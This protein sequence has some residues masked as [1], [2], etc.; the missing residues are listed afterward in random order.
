MKPNRYPYSGNKK[1]PEKQIAKCKVDSNGVEL[2]A[3]KIDF[4]GDIVP[5][6]DVVVGNLAT[7]LQ[8]V[9]TN[10]DV[11]DKRMKHAE[12]LLES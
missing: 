11:L 12:E 3:R 2:T 9:K 7:A 1:Q 8:A 4:K 10:V 6:K 5:M